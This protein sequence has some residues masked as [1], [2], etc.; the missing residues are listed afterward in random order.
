[1]LPILPEQA[2]TNDR[3]IGQLH[4]QVGV[5]LKCADDYYSCIDIPAA[6]P[7]RAASAGDHYRF[8]TSR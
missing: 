4:R 8:A 5:G 3:L 6:F 7:K 1:M 2:K